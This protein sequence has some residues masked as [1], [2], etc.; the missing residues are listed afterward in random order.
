MEAKLLLQ[1][2]CI[3]SRPGGGRGANK[4]FARTRLQEIV[5]A[6]L[7]DLSRPGGGVE[8]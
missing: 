8:I 7:T 3:N 2:L 4:N 1:A 6:H 5:V